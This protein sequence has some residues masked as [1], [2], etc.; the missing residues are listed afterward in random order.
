M[1]IG[2]S[3]VVYPAAML[4][5]IAKSSGAY[6]TEINPKRT[7]L[8]PITDLYI[9]SPSGVALGEVQTEVLELLDRKESK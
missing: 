1:S 4:P 7:D 3:A 9:G 8:T 2:T 6:L 5:Q